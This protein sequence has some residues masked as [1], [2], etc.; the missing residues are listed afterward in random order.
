VIALDFWNTG[1]AGVQNF[2]AY[3]GATYPV[4]VDAG[5]LALG[6]SY[7]IPF[8]NYLV[9]DRDGF[10]R[11]TSL[12]EPLDNVLGRFDDAHLRQAVRDY[13]PVALVPLGWDAV[14]SLYR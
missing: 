8:D 4:L 6:E 14:K 7:G 9:L 10:V 3:T 1:V 11:Y 5:D 12:G 2:V 13:L